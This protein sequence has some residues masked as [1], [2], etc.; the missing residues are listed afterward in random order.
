MIPIVTGALGTVTKGLIQGLEDVEISGQAESKHSI[1][2][3]G[4]NSE[5]RPG[6]SR[7]LAVT[8]MLV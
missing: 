1:V 8:Q 5:K 6:E 4:Q 2:E 3:D 7:R